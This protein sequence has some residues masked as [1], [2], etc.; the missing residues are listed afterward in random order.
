MD[1]QGVLWP[2]ILASL[3]LGFI[4]AWLI[5]GRRRPSGIGIDRTAEV[6]R[7]TAE[8]DAARR[9]RAE[10]QRELERARGDAAQLRSELTAVRQ[11]SRRLSADAVPAAPAAAAAVPSPRVA[12]AAPRS[13][14]VSDPE[15]PLAP[16]AGD[17][18]TRLKGVGPKLAAMLHDQGIMGLGDLASLNDDQAA[19][20]DAR[21]GSFAGRV[22]R[23]RL[24]EQAR[25][26]VEG[27]T[28]EYAARFGA[29]GV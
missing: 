21:L 2:W 19:A 8:L 20:L 29:P 26:L 15:G 6:Q 13:I 22:Q 27:R 25:L 5:F 14:I 10:A 28:A 4:L 3:A 24:P 18:L 12:G 23:D 1:P 17:D 7:L 16:G 9:D 11:D